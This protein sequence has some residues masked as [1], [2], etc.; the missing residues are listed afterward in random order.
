[1]IMTKPPA[2]WVGDFETE[3]PDFIPTTLSSKS[4]KWALN[5]SQVAATRSSQVPVEIPIEARWQTHLNGLAMAG[6]RQWLLD[7]DPDLDIHPLSLY[8]CAVLK[9]N[10]FRVGVLPQGSTGGTQVELPQAALAASV[11]PDCYVRVDVE[12]ELQ[13]V[14]VRGMLPQTMLTQQQQK[15]PL[16]TPQALGELPLYLL[17]KAWFS[18]DSE[19]LLLYLRCGRPELLRD[20]EASA[21]AIADPTAV[22]IPSH[23]L[24]NVARWFQDSISELNETLRETVS[25]DLD[26]ILMPDLSLEPS[27]MMSRDVS[28]TASLDTMLQQLVAQKILT[29][30]SAARG[31][32]YPLH[33]AGL[34]L[35]L[36]AVTWPIWT[37]TNPLEWSLVLFVSHPSGEPLPSG[38]TLEL[39]DESQVLVNVTTNEQAQQGYLYGQVMGDLAERF[40]V[41][42]FFPDGTQYH[43][44]AAFTFQPNPADLTGVQNAAQA[45]G[46]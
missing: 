14:V 18:H 40:F 15:Q 11:I 41:K 16:S 24:L 23:P 46:E 6:L 19:S 34:D 38:L 32:A 36:H 43:F 35:C 30:P 27:P 21:A 37:Q 26:W 12:E 2:D 20:T 8:P 42:L 33:I 1:M 31:A 28:L 45:E 17:P 7:H 13:R 22:P 29:I 39:A 10:Q 9:I 5:Q 25:E 3:S 44:P 4:L